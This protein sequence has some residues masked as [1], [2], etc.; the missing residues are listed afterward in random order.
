MFNKTFSRGY[1][2]KGFAGYFRGFVPV[3][4]APG[5]VGISIKSPVVIGSKQTAS[6]AGAYEVAQVRISL[7]ILQGKS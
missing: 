2:K 7:E 6:V 3:V 5:Q 1:F 4:S